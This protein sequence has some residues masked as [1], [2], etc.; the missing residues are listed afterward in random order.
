MKHVPLFSIAVLA[1]AL[2][3][4]VDLYPVVGGITMPKCTG[5]DGT[6]TCTSANGQVM[7]NNIPNTFVTA[8]QGSR[9]KNPA[10][11]NAECKTQNADCSGSA[12]KTQ[13]GCI[14]D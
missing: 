2:G 14:A 8:N 7:C 4:P 12:R 11:V 5:T 3:V 10:T 9:N 6:L 1:A 13:T